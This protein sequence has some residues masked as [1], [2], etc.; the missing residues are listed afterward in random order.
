M[1]WIVYDNRAAVRSEVDFPQGRWHSISHGVQNGTRHTQLLVRLVPETVS[2]NIKMDWV[3]DAP[4]GAS[5]W[6]TPLVR[7]LG[8]CETRP[9]GLTHLQLAPRSLF[10]D[11]PYRISVTASVG[12]CVI[13]PDWRAESNALRKFQRVIE[14]QRTIFTATTIYVHRPYAY[15]LCVPLYGTT[16]QNDP[17]PFLILIYESTEEYNMN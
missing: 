17:R 8:V 4:S 15:W 7:R 9:H 12:R 14:K 16:V 2:L 3:R 11:S 13:L 1:A 5:T 6:N 10:A